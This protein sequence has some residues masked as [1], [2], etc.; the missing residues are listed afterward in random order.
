MTSII[1]RPY[2]YATG[3]TRE[4]HAYTEE[5]WGLGGALPGGNYTS[6]SA[7]AMVLISIVAIPT[8]LVSALVFVVCLVNLKWYAIP[9]LFFTLLFGAGVVVGFKA[10]ASDFKARKLRRF[11]GLP[12]P[13]YS[14]TD[15]QAYDWFA[16]TG[17]LELTAQNFP[18]AARFQKDSAK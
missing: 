4:V 13:R 14:V 5:E 9:A 8:S 3:M 16:S 17:T 2:F 18:D 15:D 10:A 7:V 12:K 11:K 6:R 1:N